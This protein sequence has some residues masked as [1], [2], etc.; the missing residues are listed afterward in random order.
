MGRRFG[1][2]RLRNQHPPGRERN[3]GTRATGI[4]RYEFTEPARQ[5]PSKQRMPEVIAREA[6]SAGL[7]EVGWQKCGWQK[8]RLPRHSA[9]PD[10]AICPVWTVT[11]HLLSRDS[12][13]R[14]IATY[15]GQSGQ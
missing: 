9:C 8:H 2:D 15:F 3:G 13:V 14:T 12:P 11:R 10:V 4:E 7:S 6:P 5:D 1:C